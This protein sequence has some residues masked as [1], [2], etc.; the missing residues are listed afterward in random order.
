MY[1]IFSKGIKDIQNIDLFLKEESLEIENF[2]IGWG[3]K[4]TATKARKYAIETGC[5][6]L[7]IEDGFIRSKGLG[8]DGIPPSGIIVDHIGIYYDASALSE[9]ELLINNYHKWFTPAIEKRAKRL[10]K[11]LVDFDISKYN[12]GE[13][14]TEQGTKVLVVDQTYGDASIELGLA[15]EK[16]FDMMLEYVRSQYDDK[17]ISIKIHPDVITG[18]KKGC[19]SNIPSKINLIS[20][21]YTPLSLL[22]QFDEI[23][24][25]TSQMG[26]DALLLNKSV[27][28]FGSPFYAGWGLTK[29][30]GKFIARRKTKPKIEVLIA[31]IY[32]LMGRYVDH[33]NLSRISVEDFIKKLRTK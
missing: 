21:N 29:E 22:R 7:A 16:T 23:Y 27:H 12:I 11:I 18:K 14:F 3:H 17:D 5:P 31:A 10:R 4:Q 33:E 32:I 30:H 6:Y 24:C 1:Q 28:T 26:F 15:T 2:I 13:K 25:V 19:L 20:K 9:I 8:V